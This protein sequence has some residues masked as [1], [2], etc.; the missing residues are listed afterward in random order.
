MIHTA[1][2]KAK[3]SAI[4]RGDKNPFFGKKHTP[5]FRA[6]QSARTKAMNASRRYTVQPQKI[7]TPTGDWRAYLAGMVDADGSIRFKAGRPFVSIYNTH[8][9]LIVALL[10]RMGGGFSDGNLG[11]IQCYAWTI[12][13]ARDVYAFV[14]SVRPLLIVKAGDADLVLAHLVEKYEWAR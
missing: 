13:A 11:R 3:L 14:T 5:E 6:Q 8:K 12:T 10:E 7:I 1:E 4:R 2:T 9:P